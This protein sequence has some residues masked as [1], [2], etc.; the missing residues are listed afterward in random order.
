VHHPSPTDAVRRHALAALLACALLAL[1][2]PRPAAAAAGAPP[3]VDNAKGPAHADVDR[4]LTPLWSRGDESDDLFF[5]LVGA[6]VPAP[7]GGVYAL[8]SQLS[9]V[10]HL[11]ADGELLGTLGREGEGPGEFQR[12]G[13]MVLLPGGELGVVQRFPGSIVKL[14]ADG[15][16]AGTVLPGDPTTGGR[17]MLTAAAPAPG[18]LVLSG[19]HMTRRESSRLR[20]NFISLYGADGT[21]AVEYAGRDDDFDF[22]ARSFHET[23]QDFPGEDRWQVLPD[24]RVVVALERDAYTLTMSSPEGAPVLVFGR[25]AEPAARSAEELARR[26]AAWE[27]SPRFQRMGIEQV[28]ADTDPMIFDMAVRGDELW[29]LP[30]EG[31]RSAGGVLQTWDVFTAD[32]RWDRRE[33]LHVPGDGERDR[34]LF[35]DDGRAL[36]VSGFRDA[37]EAMF[38]GGTEDAGAADPVRLTLYR[39]D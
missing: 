34:L 30:R 33:R 21:V 13:A 6:A 37:L 26:R 5:G 14:H 24:G 18:G 10:Y 38:G 27:A 20:R 31:A 22:N 35:L 39:L 4:T 28:F 11:S 32:G 19:A 1:S 29:V 16:P 25:P 8:D 23:D 17:D 7:D 2:A 3:R 12:A 9:T 36:L 15:T